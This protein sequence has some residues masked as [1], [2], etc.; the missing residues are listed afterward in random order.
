MPCHRDCASRRALPSSAPAACKLCSRHAASRRNH[1]TVC[2]LRLLGISRLGAC[3]TLD[4]WRYPRFLMRR[5]L[6]CSADNSAGAGRAREL[7]SSRWAAHRGSASVTR[8]GACG[9]QRLAVIPELWGWPISP[10]MRSFNRCV[11]DTR[12]TPEP[13]EFHQLLAQRRRMAS[14]VCEWR[15]HRNAKSAPHSGALGSQTCTRL[16]PKHYLQEIEHA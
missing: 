8:G 1:Q 11:T 16:H 5:R 9:L 13:T 15:R 7:A 2:R 12:L 14:P 6:G 3:A 10:C 4:S